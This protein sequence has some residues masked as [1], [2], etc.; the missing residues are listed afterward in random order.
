MMRYVD[1]SKAV[2]SR[3]KVLIFQ[4]SKLSLKDLYL[5]NRKLFPARTWYLALRVLPNYY[6][7]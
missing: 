4:K 2:N 6:I 1:L 3:S 7:L 5:N